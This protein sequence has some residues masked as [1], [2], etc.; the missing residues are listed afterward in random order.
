VVKGI[1]LPAAGEGGGFVL[2]EG[3]APF[4][5]SSALFDYQDTAGVALSPIVPEGSVPQYALLH[6]LTSLSG[7]PDVKGFT[8]GTAAAPASVIDSTSDIATDAPGIQILSVLNALEPLAG[9][10]T[11]EVR[12]LETVGAGSPASGGA[13]AIVFVYLP[14]DS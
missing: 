3:T 1:F 14:P 5:Y 12:Y 6:T 9:D 11:L 8:L 2:P 10:T 7:E 13:W 4:V